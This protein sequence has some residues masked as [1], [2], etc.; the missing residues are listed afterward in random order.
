[1]KSVAS[2]MLLVAFAAASLAGC[3]TSRPLY[4]VKGGTI[5]TPAGV[6]R[7]A[8]DVEKAIRNAGTATG[9]KM[10]SPKPGLIVASYSWR[11][12][13]AVVDITYDARTYTIAYKDST[14]LNY[15]GTNIHRNYNYYVQE[16]EKAIQGQLAVF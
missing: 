4:N 11:S 1:M 2:G 13:T 8:S 12:H 16:L 14:N 7:T 5:E 6:T 10:Q 9:W 3:S 15:D